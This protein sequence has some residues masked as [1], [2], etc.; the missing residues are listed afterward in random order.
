MHNDDIFKA[1]AN[2]V[3]R[4]ILYWLKEIYVHF[5]GLEFPVEWGIPAGQIN[6]R[7]GLSQSA[8]SSHLAIL[9]RANLLSVHK[10]G[11][12]TFFRRNEA[13]IETFLEML[14]GEL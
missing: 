3:R 10:A 6:R 11:S 1:L 14:Q 2:P 13:V 9:Q 8:I 4:N 12:W 7:A 5:P